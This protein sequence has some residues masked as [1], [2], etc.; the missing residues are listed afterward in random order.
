MEQQ[1]HEGLPRAHAAPLDHKQ[2]AKYNTNILEGR[3]KPYT[4]GMLACGYYDIDFAA[5][6]N[7]V[8]PGK[9]TFPQGYSHWSFTAANQEN[10]DAVYYTIANTNED[11]KK[12]VSNGGIVK[13]DWSNDINGLYDNRYVFGTINLQIVRILTLNTVT[14][15]SITDNSHSQT[16]NIAKAYSLT[17][18]FGNLVA[19]EP[20]AEE[21]Y[22]ADYYEY[23]GVQ[24]ATFGSDIKVADDAEGKVNLRTLASLNMTADVDN[25]SGELKF[26]NNGAPLQAN[27]YLI[28]P[29]KVTH[30]WGVLEGHI[31]VPLNKS[32]APLNAPR[33]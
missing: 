31:A 3:L 12:L 4:T 33:N 14:S 24:T 1:H 17:D 26:Q 6:G 23:Y 19:A 22:A 11:G 28:V 27:A 7:P 16:I 20:T 21:P 29:V 8:Y 13:V 9:L 32:N 25:V 18:A 30:L 15:Q 2:K 5:T 10:L